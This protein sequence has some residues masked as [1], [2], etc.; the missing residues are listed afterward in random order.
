MQNENKKYIGLAK[1]FHDAQR[2]A[3][4]G[5]IQHAK[6]G[7]IYFNG[8]NIA[9]GQSKERFDENDVV[10]FKSRQSESKK[11]SLEAID[12]VLIENEKEIQ[13]LF[14]HFLS[15]FTEK[16]TYSDYNLLQNKV[17]QS[18]QVL[19]PDVEDLDKKE[20]IKTFKDFISR[21]E[22]NYQNA[23]TIV[24]LT[25]KLFK[26]EENQ[27]ISHLII[28]LD[29][30]TK[31]KFWLEEI[32]DQPDIDFIAEK[33]ISE[34]RISQIFD[35]CDSKTKNE[36]FFKLV[37]DLEAIESDQEIN[38]A[39]KIFE[40]CRKYNEEGYAKVSEK[41]IDHSPS[42]V[43]LSFWLK[44]FID[45]FDYQ[46]FVIYTITLSIKEQKAFLK[47]VLKLIH[48]KKVNLTL[49]DLEKIITTDLKLY[50]EIG[51]DENELNDL[52]FTICIILQVI[53]DLSNEVV[54]KRETIFEIIANQ[55]N[56]PKDLL[57]ITGFFD[58]CN[59]RCEATVNSIKNDEGEEIDKEIELKKLEEKPRFAIY[60][61]GRKSQSVCT[62]TGLDF[63]WCENKKCY[64]PE[65]E[66][67][68]SENWKDY[69][70]LDILTIL[71]VNF[72][73][74]DYE[75][76]LNVINKANRFLSHLS[77]RECKSILRPKG[78]TNYSF[79]GVSDF[80]CKNDN[81]SKKYEKIY[82]SH[83]LNGRC[84][85]IID[86]RDCV[87]CKPVG[88]E[89]C[90]WYVCNYCNACCYSLQLKKRKW[91]YDDIL[92]SEYKCHLKGH[93]DLGE[94]AC[95]KCGT[96]MNSN[97]FSE[98]NFNRTLNWFIEN[99]NNNPYIKKSGQ[100]EDGKWWFTFASNNLSIEEYRKKLTSLLK[101]GFKIPDY[102]KEDKTLQLI[103]EPSSKSRANNKD[104]FSCPNCNHSIDLN[105]DYQK[106]RAMKGFHTNLF[107][108][109]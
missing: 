3:D 63:W 20:L 22:L 64:K 76:L 50:Q 57:E 23:K 108:D 18:I 30:E 102:D 66:L 39:I 83:C 5:F 73:E 75:V 56:R 34:N 12:V 52:D 16:G 105:S 59:G 8:R 103:A 88:F 42:Y 109:E 84:G 35:R 104:V 67:H 70:L 28:Y 46:E 48:E 4:Y 44:D 93:K 61:D 62:T 92:K 31:Y 65:R 91:V 81:C 85:E 58:E 33:V 106:Y 45:Y 54:T 68:S 96:T 86:S 47:K 60:C 19:Y 71:K 11:G 79:W 17:F 2:N 24:N 36:I 43:K 10:I 25:Q 27:I 90:G 100:R 38:Q 77:C 53:K 6:L 9:K 26:E 99:R 40:L 14:E 32:H 97:E 98:D 49:T 51:I 29:R 82:I 74:K 95:N 41:I 78:K 37:Y 101:L 21:C 94:I 15:I 87:T 1:W 89:D 7:D 69:S 13:F 55:V 80:Y 72:Q 107:K